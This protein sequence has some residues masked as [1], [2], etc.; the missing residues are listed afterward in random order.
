M[1][2]K[3]NSVNK[4]AVKVFLLSLVFGL[5][6]LFLFDTASAQ[7]SL[8]SLSISLVNQDPYPA[9]PDSYVD[10]LFQVSGVNNPNCYGAR[11]Q[12]LPSY[13]FSLDTNDSLK[14]LDGNTWVSGYKN[15]WMV[16]YKV[17]VDKDALDG[18]SEIEVAYAPGTWD[19]GSFIYKK[20][21]ITI[22][23]SRT[24]FDA[25]I[26]EVSNSDVSIAIANAGKNTANSVVVRIPEQEYFR[27]TGTDG[28]M[29]GNLESGDYTI[30]SFSVSAIA[31]QGAYQRRANNSGASAQPPTQTQQ[32]NNLKFDIYYTDNL[33]ER[34]VVNMAL[35]VRMSANSSI[36]GIFSGSRQVGMRNN[37]KSLLSNLYIWAPVL[38]ALIIAA[39][40]IHRKIKHSKEASISHSKETP[41]WISKKEKK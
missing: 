13:P 16:P 23:D 30:V 31:A 39:F 24:N 9:I 20:F 8:C 36:M 33:G 3:Q 29:V 35:P 5:V 26:Q 11:L 10:V 37:N 28:Q 4:E 25:V 38:L 34:R 19:V 2:M 15:D 7:T 6:I 18:I 41:D 12:L 17:R 32:A 40:F 21:N 22:E 27:A 14:T 1:K